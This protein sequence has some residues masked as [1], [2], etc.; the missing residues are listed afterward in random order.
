MFYIAFIP[1]VISLL[2]IF[3][4]KEKKVD[5][6]NPKEGN[7]FSFLSYWNISSFEY[8][9][10]VTGLV[11]FAVAN[12][13]DVFLLL[14][15]K[16]ISQSDNITIA[17]YVFYNIV[18]AFASYPLG[19]LAD[20]IGLK[21]VFIS[22]LVLFGVVYTGFAFVTSNYGIFLM[23]FTYGLYAAATEGIAKAWV[24]NIAHNKH[25]A[26]AIGFYTSFQSICTL[27]ASLL[28]GYLWTAYGSATTFL[29]SAFLAIAVVPIIA[30]IREPK[31]QGE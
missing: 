16:E 21:K 19:M 20:R 4:I 3:L 27:I 6:V 25:T 18:F 11:L 17:A 15:T 8:K 5:H 1:G 23:F 26:T 10:L 9:R 28:A 2:L 7:F 31:A 24:T 13:S 22:G 29:V 30:S 12:S 14:K